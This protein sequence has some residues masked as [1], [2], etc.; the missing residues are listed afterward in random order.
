MVI[1][2]D[3]RSYSSGKPSEDS[4]AVN[5]NIEGEEIWYQFIKYSINEKLE[6][7]LEI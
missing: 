5:V 4:V 2:G 6:V 7:D 3:I 1:I